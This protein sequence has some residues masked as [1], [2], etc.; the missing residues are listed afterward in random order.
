VHVPKKADANSFHR[1]VE[2][3]LRTYREYVIGIPTMQ[4]TEQNGKG[5]R[6]DE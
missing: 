4:S 5:F 2:R 1:Q 3:L 6:R